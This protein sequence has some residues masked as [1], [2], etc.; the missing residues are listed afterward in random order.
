L[1]I[2]VH[3][4]R[5]DLIALQWQLLF[6]LRANLYFML[7]MWIFFFIM[8]L[9]K[10]ESFSIGSI[11]IAAF[12]ALLGAAAG[13]LVALAINAI[14]VLM[15]PLENKGILGRHDISLSPT[16]FREIT[17]VND[18][19]YRWTGIP[20]VVALPRCLVVQVTYCAAYPVPRRAFDS[21]Q[22][23]KAFCDYAEGAWRQARLVPETDGGA[24]NTKPESR[25]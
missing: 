8:P 5:F 2:T 17:D 9:A 10:A 7:A 12:V 13:M 3:L 21:E 20:R 25:S 24:G 16:E 1:K 4:T 11:G 14:Y 18:S 23:F 22:E 15:S 6:R 19:S